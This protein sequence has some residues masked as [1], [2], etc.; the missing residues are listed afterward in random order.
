MSSDNGGCFCYH[1]IMPLFHYR[2]RTGR[3]EQV[4]GNREAT[5]QY[6]L[7]RTLRTEG[8]TVI[9]IHE[10]EAKARRDVRDYAPV[11]LQPLLFPI[12]LE[13]KMNFTRN[14]A[15]MVGAG[16]S[17]AKALEVMAR[18]TQNTRF[19][20]IIAAMAETIK[21]GKSFA[22]AIGE[23]PRVF[24]KFY[25]EMVRA[26]ERSGKLQDS[27]KLIALQLHKDY[28]LRRK[29]QSAMMYPLIIIV[30]MV[31]I[32]ILMMIYVVPT[33]VSTFEELN[34]DLPR[35]TQFIIFVSK[36]LVQSGLVFLGSIIVLGAGFYRGLRTSRGKRVLDWLFVR[37]PIIG[38]MTIKFN[39]AR[40][41]RTLSSL[42]SSG[43]NI[44]EALEITKGVLQN[45]LHQNVL[46]Q[47]REKIQ[48]GETLA[49]S[50]LSA[51]R[52]YPPLVGEMIAVGEETGELSSMLLR[53]AVFYENE[54]SAETKDLSTIIE[55]VLMIIIGAVVGFFA[56]S[57]ISPMYSLVA[58][59]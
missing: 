58:G 39:A 24:P 12:K 55:P 26:G 53:L 20:K 56:V 5:D 47:A 46:D 52:L 45:H 59:L 49:N 38:G 51:E 14:I 35:S 22:D 2:A 9:A 41:C 57:M 3:G 6:A 31:G 8:L 18:Q 23:H 4:D 30:A 32:G 42:I 29:V 16:L 43:V 40:T 11:F 17:L 54:V 13:E 44:L 10:G 15:V 50:F 34:V 25:Q 21:K 37:V 28:A 1:N 7:A 33:L 48:R 36:S 19:K 27:L